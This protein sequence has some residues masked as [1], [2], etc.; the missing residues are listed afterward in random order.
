ML[1]SIIIPAYNEEKTVA[2]IIKKVQKIRLPKNLIKEIIVIDD[3]STDSTP[4]IIKNIKGIKYVSHNKNFGKGAAVL[5]GIRNSKGDFI[6][7][8]DAD[9]E[10]D[11]KY[12]PHIIEPILKGKAKVVYGTRLKNY[13]LKI[14]G[15]K[16]TP[17]IT[18][19][20]GNKFLSFITNILFGKNVSDMETGYKVFLSSILSGI[21]IKAKGFDFEPEITAKLLKKGFKIY[22]VPIKVNPRGYDEGKKITWKDGI[23]AFWTLVKYR[24][25]D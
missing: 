25:V 12:I 4:K 2:K 11:P 24:F 14:L 20:L 21:E 16:R 19:Y 13:P 6:L 5:T 15:K 8:Q 18:H 17:L 7:I 22:E 3:G 10:Y 1:L 9:L 23:V